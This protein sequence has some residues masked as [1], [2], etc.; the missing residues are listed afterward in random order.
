MSTD[1]ALIAHLRE[2]LDPLGVFSARAMF[3][4]WGIYL[5]GIIVGLVD[6]GVC[7]LKADA[8]S[9]PR[10]EAAG[11]VQFT[12]PS[13]DGPMA[14]SYWTLPAD[15]L[16]SPEAMAPWARLAQAAALRKRAA[17]KPRGTRKPART[18][19]AGTPSPRKPR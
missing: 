11:S 16:D 1:L 5:D 8:S 19:R 14:M 9:Q 18:T 4:G 3:G 2:L 10:F 7:Y 17:A 13:K 12:Y 6:E 15:A